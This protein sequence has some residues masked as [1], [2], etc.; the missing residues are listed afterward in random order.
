ADVLDE[1]HLVVALL[2]HRIVQDLDGIL[3]IAR[4]EEPHRARDTCRCLLETLALRI[5]AELGE[6]RRDCQL[7]PI[8]FALAH[9][10]ASPQ[11]N[12]SR[13]APTPRPRTPRPAAPAAP[14]GRSSRSTASAIGWAVGTAVANHGSSFSR[15]CESR[16][17]MRWRTIASSRSIGKIEPVRAS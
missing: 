3:V 6:H 8:D 14:G 12:E 10:S 11:A 16:S 5:L 2:E 4:R 17:T 1:H 13:R 15:R 9:P 7:D